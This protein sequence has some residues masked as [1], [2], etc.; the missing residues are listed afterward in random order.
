MKN[1]L[2]VILGFLYLTMLGC[3]TTSQKSAQ[4]KLPVTQNFTDV[5]TKLGSAEVI[6][7]D[8]KKTGLINCYLGFAKHHLVLKML[9]LNE[10]EKGKFSHVCRSNIVLKTKYERKPLL[11]FEEWKFENIADSEL[12]QQRLKIL[13]GTLSQPEQVNNELHFKAWMIGSTLQI[14][15]TKNENGK[16]YVN[17]LVDIIKT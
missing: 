2:V 12:M 15:Y 8:D 7:V 13:N 16:S 17:S 6:V 1:S 9:Q 11:A 10:E 5:I 3:N 14:V 4:P